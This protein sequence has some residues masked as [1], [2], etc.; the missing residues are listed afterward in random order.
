MKETKIINFFGGPG[1]GKS[2]Q[3]AGLYSLMKKN[4]MSVELT[5][6]FPKIL[7]WDENHSA[8]K[9]QLYITANQHRNISR[10][11][12]KVEYIIVDSPILFGMVYKDKYG[13]DYP[14]G[15]YGDTFDTFLL[16]LF[17][18]Y[19]NINILLRRREESYDEVGRFQ[20]LKESRE[21]D[22]MLRDLLEN[23]EISY[24][25]FEVNKN[26]ATT[27][28]KTLFEDMEEKKWDGGNIVRINPCKECGN[29]EGVQIETHPSLAECKV[30]QHLCDTK[31][32]E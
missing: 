11:Y 6:E 21:I 31:D 1:I 32:D 12:G 20:D 19:H 5:Y 18:K 25:E 13:N 2:T 23:N 10:L 27:I 3:A 14:Q 15:L 8:I 24:H 29:L 30:C 22:G 4:N 9:D 17:Q 16:D 28:Y 26:S 7:A